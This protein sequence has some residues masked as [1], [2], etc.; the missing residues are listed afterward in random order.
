MGC[1]AVVSGAGGD[2]RRNGVN[3]CSTSRP[4]RIPM[5]A[6]RLYM[7]KDGVFSVFSRLVHVRLAAREPQPGYSGEHFHPPWRWR[8]PFR[9]FPWP[10]HARACRTRLEECRRAGSRRFARRPDS[11][12]TLTL[13]THQVCHVPGGLLVVFFCSG[14]A[15]LIW[16]GSR[17]GENLRCKGWILDK[18]RQVSM[19]N[20]E[21]AVARLSM[22]GPSQA[23]DPGDLTP[24]PTQLVSL[25]PQPPSPPALP[26]LPFGLS[27]R[28]KKEAEMPRRTD[29]ALHRIW[30]LPQ[31]LS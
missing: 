24:S 5:Q 4:R 14:R 22:S 23:F 7:C 28:S 1:G 8:A 30:H 26:P 12:C 25:A 10:I 15:R 19:F 9:P 16:S 27:T 13:T 6:R 20:V 2:K 3:G 18:D 31:Q 17:V 11:E 21:F 29:N